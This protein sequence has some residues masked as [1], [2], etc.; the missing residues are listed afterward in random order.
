MRTHVLNP[1]S[2]RACRRLVLLCLAGCAFMFATGTTKDTPLWVGK[3]KHRILV[4]VDPLD[5]GKRA[6]DEMPARIHMSAQ[7]VRARECAAGKIDVSSLEVEQY[8]PRT[9]E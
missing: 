7:D 3:G 8:N 5:T 9:G 2:S 6:A 4:R 1:R